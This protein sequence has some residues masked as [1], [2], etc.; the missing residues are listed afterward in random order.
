MYVCMYVCM[1]NIYIHISTYAKVQT[2]VRIYVYMVK[3][4]KISI[5]VVCSH[6][7]IDSGS[8]TGAIQ[9]LALEESL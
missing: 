6:S 8:T 4:G 3:Y 1:C 2:H 7:L 9:R 5:R